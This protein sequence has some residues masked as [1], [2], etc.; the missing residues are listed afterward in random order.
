MKWNILLK[1]RAKRLVVKKNDQCTYPKSHSRSQNLQ[2]LSNLVKGP[3]NQHGLEIKR[4]P[5]KAKSFVIL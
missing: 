4:N 3:S 5:R 2:D 1:I